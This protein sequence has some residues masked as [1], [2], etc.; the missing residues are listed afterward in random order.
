MPV[1]VYRC[2]HCHRGVLVRQPGPM[3]DAE[4]RRRIAEEMRP[5]ARGRNSR[6]DASMRLRDDIWVAVSG[7]RED[8]IPRND[9]PDECPACG[10]RDALEQSRMLEG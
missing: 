5:W 3:S 8:D 2:S 10:R 9:V 6:V 4:I 7:M 1:Q